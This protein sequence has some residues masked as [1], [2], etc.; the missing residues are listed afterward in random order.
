MITLFQGIVISFAVL[1]SASLISGMVWAFF[2]TY[3][4]YIHLMNEAK[5]LQAR[6]EVQE[7]EHAQIL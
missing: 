6:Y 1:L 3:E 2:L 7:S 4:I 5:E